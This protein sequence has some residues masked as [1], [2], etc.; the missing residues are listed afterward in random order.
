MAE[1]IYLLGVAVPFRAVDVSS[2]CIK[3]KYTCGIVKFYCLCGHGR[4]LLAS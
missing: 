1:K 3:Y 4:L 2:I